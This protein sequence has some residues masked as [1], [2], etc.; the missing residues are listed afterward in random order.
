MLGTDL[1][2]VHDG[3]ATVQLEGIVELGQTFLGVIV[4]AVLDPPIGLHEDRRAEVLVGVP[5]VRRTGGRAASAQDALVHAIELGPVLPALEVFGLSVGLALG[6]LE[7]GF[8]GTVL[9]VEVAHVGNEVLDDVHVREG[10][11]LGGLAGRVAGSLGLDV[12]QAGQGVGA[13]DVHGARAADALPAGAA[14]G[15]GGVLLVL[16]LE[17]CV[18]DHRAAVVQVHGIGRQVRLLLLIGIPSVDLEVLDP[19]RLG[20]WG[21]ILHLEGFLGEGRCRRCDGSGTN[22]SG[23]RSSGCSVQLGGLRCDE[24]RAVTE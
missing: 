10:V 22:N 3:V 6:V 20:R 13:V 2:A 4:A 12:A 24:I 16:D 21:G 5:P 19:L 11:D 23:S 7:P 8:D 9:L 1:G 17:E 14:E 18:E 15:E